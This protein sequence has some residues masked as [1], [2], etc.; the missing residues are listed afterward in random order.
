MLSPRVPK[1][2]SGSHRIVA[3][4]LSFQLAP[5]N[6]SVEAPVMVCP[7]YAP[8]YKPLSLHGLV[9]IVVNPKGPEKE[10]S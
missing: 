9:A 5:G 8:R 6:F 2:D 3:D 4:Q 10:N 7:E 1:N